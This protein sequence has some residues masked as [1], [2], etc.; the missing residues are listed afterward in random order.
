MSKNVRYAQL[1]TLLLAGA[2]IAPPSFA[3]SKEKKKKKAKQEATTQAAPAAVKKDDNGVKPYASVIT[4]NA[5]TDD[6]LF[7]VH[8][9]D[10]K[11][12]YEIP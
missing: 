4:P 10:E 8:R 11:Y 5:V 2:L 1:A 3:Q 7:K 12:F 9:I 6:G